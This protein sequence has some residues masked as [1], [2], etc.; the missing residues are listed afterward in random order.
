[1]N[2]VTPLVDD[3]R[4]NI[5]QLDLASKEYIMNEKVRINKRFNG[6]V[7]EHVKKIL[8]ESIYLGT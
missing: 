6:K 1:M 7:S 8:T 4:K 3:A 5:V 2:K